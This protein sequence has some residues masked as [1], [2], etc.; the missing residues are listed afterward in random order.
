MCNLENTSFFS[1][2]HICKVKILLKSFFVKLLW[3]VNEILPAMP[4]LTPRLRQSKC[5]HDQCLLLLFVQG[6]TREWYPVRTDPSNLSQKRSSPDSDNEAWFYG[7]IWNFLWF[8]WVF[9]PSQ[10]GLLIVLLQ[11]WHLPVSEYEAEKQFLRGERQREAGRG[12]CSHWKTWKELYVHTCLFFKECQIFPISLCH[13]T[14]VC[15]LRMSR[16]SQ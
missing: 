11:F 6:K 8:W 14:L 2:S 10:M 3:W 4:C 7:G 13:S 16:G 9:F 1:C 15:L 12:V 5:K